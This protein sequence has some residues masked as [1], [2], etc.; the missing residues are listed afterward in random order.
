MKNGRFAKWQSGF[1]L[2][3]LMIVVAIIGILAAIA[4][5]AYQDYVTR[6]RVVEGMSLAAGA[7]TTVSENA[8]NGVP[9]TAG[10]AAPS[11]T[12]NVSSVAIAADGIITISYTV[13]AGNGTIVMTPN[14][15]LVAGTVPADRIKWDCLGGSLAAK[16]RPA[17]CR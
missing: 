3:E 15:V 6:A 9:L 17:E 1:T 2:I 4:I 13:R 14:P 7:K 12:N 16:Y 8:Y 10:F 5:P 11:A